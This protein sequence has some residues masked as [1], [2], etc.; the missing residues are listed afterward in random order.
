MPRGGRE[1]SY[2]NYV[3]HSVNK[4]SM[5]SSTTYDYMLLKITTIITATIIIIIIIIIII[6]SARGGGG[7]QLSTHQARIR[8]GSSPGDTVCS[9]SKG[10]DLSARPV[11]PC[12]HAAEKR[13]GE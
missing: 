13:R 12:S 9:G 10:C 4:T 2:M 1:L 11:L 8:N 3:K 7:G 5:Y 6:Y